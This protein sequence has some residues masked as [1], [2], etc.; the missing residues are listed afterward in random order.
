MENT[1]PQI[2]GHLLM[3]YFLVTMDKVTERQQNTYIK[4]LDD[5]MRHQKVLARS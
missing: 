1:H 5:K 4:S 2:A 3:N